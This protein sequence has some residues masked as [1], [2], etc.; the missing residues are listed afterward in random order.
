[1]ERDP[2]LVAISAAVPSMMGFN[3]S[4]RARAGKQ[5]VD[6]GIAEE[7][8]VAMASGLATAGAHPVFG[9][10]S[11][12]FQRTYDQLSQDVCINRSPVS[13]VVIAGSVLGLNDVTHLGFFDIPLISNIPNMVY[14]APT[15]VEE[16]LAMLQWSIDQTGGP[17]RHSMVPVPTDYSDL[18][19][20]EVTSEGSRV[21][22]L[23]LG[24]F[25]SLAV[26]VAARLKAEAGIAATVVNPRYVTGID[27]ALLSRLER[28]HEVVVTI[29]DGV[30]DGGFGEK[31]ARHYGPT[32]MRVLNYGL[33]KEFVDRY[34]YSRILADNRLTAPQIT[35]DVLG[36]LK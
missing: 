28:N 1:M 20:Y 24:T 30:L 14:L 23:G 4:R 22:L 33:K 21:A 36:L 27:A 3:V 2:L 32:A 12:F 34:D 19:R 6:V 25:H 17:V 35:A 31:I 26:E 5:Y 7:E 29:E 13:L 11:T 16:Y 8:A 18:N 9:T 10:V 15:T